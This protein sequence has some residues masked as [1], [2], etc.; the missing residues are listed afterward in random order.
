MLS[1]CPHHNLPVWLFCLLRATLSNHV[2]AQ[3]NSIAADAEPTW[4]TLQP[5]L[6]LQQRPKEDALLL[7]LDN[8]E[9]LLRY[10]DDSQVRT[11]LLICLK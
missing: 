7:V 10:G 5:W 11:E 8:A 4:A 2:L 1:A 3:G 9:E 6:H